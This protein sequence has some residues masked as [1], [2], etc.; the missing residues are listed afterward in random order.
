MAEQDS[1]GMVAC[2]ARDD[3]RVRHRPELGIKQLHLM[4]GID[5]RPTDRQ[6]AKRGQ[7][8]ARNPAAD[9]GVWWIDEQDAHGRPSIG[10]HRGNTARTIGIA[11][12][13]SVNAGRNNLR[14]PS[15]AVSSQLPQKSRRKSLS[16]MPWQATGPPSRLSAAFNPSGA[17]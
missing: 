6:Q 1:I 13:P 4:S 16:A 9:R 15:F 14:R 5:Q 3:L 10:G 11:Q 12:R 2:G 7:L 8:L 17:V